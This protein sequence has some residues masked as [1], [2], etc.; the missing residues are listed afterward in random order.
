MRQRK[1]ILDLLFC[2]FPCILMLSYLSEI[3]GRQVQMNV[4]LSILA[5]TLT[6]G[7][8]IGYKIG[9][10]GNVYPI[11]AAAFLS[12][13]G[14]I[15]FGILGWNEWKDI[16]LF[17]VAGGA[18]FGVTQYL[19][20]RL[21]RTALKLGPL[22]PAWCAQSLNFIP[23]IIYS[24]TC[25]KENLSFW[26]SF[27][28]FF[29][30]CAIFAAACNTSGGKRAESLKGRLAY[31]GLLVSILVCISILNVGLKYGAVNIHPATG[32]T[33]LASNGNLIMCVTYLFLGLSSALDL[34]ISKSWRFN[35]FAFYGGGIV[36]VCALLSFVFALIVVPRAP[37]VVFFALSNA[38]SILTAGLLS[39]IF[40]KE[41]RTKAWYCTIIFSLLAILFNR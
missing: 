27:A 10:M 32:R 34:T 31:G 17:T 40:M 15:V 30:I 28:L 26:Q 5:G 1:Y 33:L 22:S 35:K 37:A 6:G 25:L 16:C 7:C 23:V 20:I 41:K 39:T 29:T 2:C 19:G 12:V 14:T 11:Q 3:H 4:F 13:F 21:L 38:S 36:T 8:G 24:C 9:G 18:F